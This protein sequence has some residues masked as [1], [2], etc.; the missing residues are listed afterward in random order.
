MF[1]PARVPM[2]LL[3]C[4]TVSPAVSGPTAPLFADAAALEIEFELDMRRL[5]RDPT[6]GKCADLPAAIAY[7]ADDGTRVRLDVTVR[8]RGRWN[9]R[10]SNCTVPAL[11]IFFDTAQTPGTLFEGQSMLPFTSHCRHGS[12]KYHAYAI[13]EYLAHRIYN[14]LT[15]ASLQV[16]LANVAYIDNGSNV[17]YRRYGFF[18]EHFAR[19]AD[20]LD[21]ELYDVDTLDP[22]ATDPNELAT[23]SIFQYMIGNLD[24]SVR[25]QHNIAL[26]RRAN[27]IVV[28]LPYDFDYSGLVDAEYAAPP[29]EFHLRDVR[30]RLYRGYCRPGIE[31]E[32]LFA[33]F[34][35]A[36]PDISR[37]VDEL[38]DISSSSAFRRA[39][40]FLG[41]FWRIIWS[42]AKRT[43]EIV[44]ACR[45]LPAP[46]RDQP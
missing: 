44:D 2:V 22:R 29:S 8:T 35:A 33:I 30:K 27:G 37:M 34:V 20:R 26:V 31:W 7:Y 23:L 5:C 1:R 39:N 12:R 42:D 43:R 40:D 19:A 11:F 32:R 13:K 10:T 21:A 16:R 36:R 9:R 41:G 24:W 14:L 18:V 45:R 46:L 17:R 15:A 3:A 4:L 28:A 38:A 6:S 25:K